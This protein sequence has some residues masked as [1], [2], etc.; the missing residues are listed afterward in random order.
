MD[1]EDSLLGMV[2]DGDVPHPRSSHRF[3]DG[4][5]I[6]DIILTGPPL[7]SIRR[8]QF[9]IHDTRLVT[10]LPKRPRPIVGTGTGFHPDATRGKISKPGEDFSP[11]QRTSKL[12]MLLLVDTIENETDLD[13]SIPT[14]ISSDVDLPLV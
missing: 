10:E 14:R 1:D 8:G 5:G 9:G 7:V 13:R 4:L 6:V 3:A 12:A 11:F 2:L